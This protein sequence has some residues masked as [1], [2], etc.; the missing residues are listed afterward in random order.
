MGNGTSSSKP[1]SEASTSVKESDHNDVIP[2]SKSK[3]NKSKKSGKSTG[4]LQWLGSISSKSQKNRNTDVTI[5]QDD[6]VENRDE[7]PYTET[8]A[9][10]QSDQGNYIYNPRL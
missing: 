2:S 1:A 9:S 4:I 10:L 6:L 5:A 3:S 7:L 8:E